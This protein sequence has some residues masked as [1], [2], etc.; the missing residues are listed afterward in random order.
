MRIT[1]LNRAVALAEIAGPETALEDV[2]ALDAPGLA[3]FLPY[4]AVRADLLARIGLTDAAR[5]GL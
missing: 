5:R 4:H 1:R 3:D 2:D